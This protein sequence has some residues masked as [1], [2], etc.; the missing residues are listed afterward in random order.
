[1]SRNPARLPRP[2]PPKPLQASNSN[3]RGYTYRWQLASQQFLKIHP[4]CKHCNDVG[5]VTIATDVDHIKPH[6]GNMA[7]FWDQKNWQ[8]LC[9]SCHG[10]KS[11]SE[12]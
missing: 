6:K 3:E 8:S 9:K 4:L 11:A 7:V 5:I 1:M 12:A 10:K 2:S